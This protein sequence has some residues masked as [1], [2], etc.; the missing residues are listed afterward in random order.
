MLLRVR[1]KILHRLANAL[2][3]VDG[4]LEIDKPRQAKLELRA[5][6]HCCHLL[7]KALAKEEQRAKK[8][9]CRKAA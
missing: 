3:A 6:V 2:Q 8:E 4:Y 5:A 7:Q 1:K 9:G